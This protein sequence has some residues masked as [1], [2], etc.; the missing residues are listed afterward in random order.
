[1]S[2][3]KKIKDEYFLKLS[4]DL[5]INQINQIK[6]DLFGKNGLVSSQFKQL[7]KIAE[8]ERKKFASELNNVKDE[9]QKLIVSKIEEIEIKEINQ[10]L[11][12]EKVDITLPERPF[13]DGK[14][15]PVSQV[16]DEISSIFS[17]IGFSVEEGPDVENEY[18]NF[19]ALNTPD[20]HPARDMHDTFYLDEKKE[21]LL[22]THTSPV[23]IRTML[24]D[25]P[26]FKII[27]PGRTY[28]SDS[29]Q[30]HAPMFHQVEGLH[31]DKDINM[32][33]LKGCLNYFIKE[34]FE[35]DKIKMRFRPSHFPFTEPS[36]EVDIGYEIKDGKI[37][38]GEG[39]K[40]LEILGCGMVHPNVLKNVNVDPGEFQGYAFGIGIDRLAMLKYGINDLR[41]FFDCDYRW[42]NQFGFDPI[43]VPSSYRGLSR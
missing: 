35:V 14:I 21:L 7:S 27:A 25:K 39:N 28:R 36:A 42:L 6:T 2:D 5:D 19:T 4:K 18:N 34:F 29:D 24:N 3:I 1:M 43:D 10:K 22:R 38:I 15:H 8:D 32:G 26:P 16:I 41:A 23:Q 37:I 33:H 9:L 13:A 12:K 20:N 30:T 11:E 31:I 17:E 40:W